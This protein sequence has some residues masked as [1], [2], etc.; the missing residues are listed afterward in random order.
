VCLFVCVRVSLSC[1]HRTHQCTEWSV[2][3]GAAIAPEREGDQCLRGGCWLVCEQKGRGECAC[4]GKVQASDICLGLPYVCRG[5]PFVCNPVENARGRLGSQTTAKVRPQAC[6]AL[7]SV[8][9]GADFLGVDWHASSPA[10][11]GHALAHVAGRLG[12]APKLLHDT[13][14]LKA[15]VQLS[16]SCACVAG[17]GQGGGSASVG[18]RLQQVFVLRYLRTSRFVLCAVVT[19]RKASVTVYLL[20]ILAR[21]RCGRHLSVAAS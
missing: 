10:V 18:C 13:L 21:D 7:I 8:S 11:A 2:P 15:H 4:T 12:L 20:R 14:L 1:L 9:S 3:R 5:L 6:T 19:V 16:T 17:R